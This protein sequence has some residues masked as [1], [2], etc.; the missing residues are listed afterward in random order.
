MDCILYNGVI[1]SWTRL[2]NFHFHRHNREK[3]KPSVQ[4]SHRGQSQRWRGQKVERR[5]PGAGRVGRRSGQLGFNGTE[6]VLVD[7]KSPMDGW[8]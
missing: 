4:C 3:V 2:G 6:L 5:M 1:K 7:E 8:C